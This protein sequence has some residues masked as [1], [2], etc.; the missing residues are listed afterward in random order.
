MH[1]IDAHDAP[2]DSNGN[3]P[4]AGSGTLRDPDSGHQTSFRPGEAIRL[5]LEIIAAAHAVRTENL[6]QEPYTAAVREAVARYGA[7]DAVFLMAGA[8]ATIL[9]LQAILTSTSPEA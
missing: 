1:I 2:D 6:A 8:A 4:G 5:S 9:E 7:E 3:R